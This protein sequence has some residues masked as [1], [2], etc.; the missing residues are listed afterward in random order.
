MKKKVKR[1]KKYN[2][3]KPKEENKN[4]DLHDK[5]KKHLDALG[6]RDLDVNNPMERALKLDK[7]KKNPVKPG[8]MKIEVY[9]GEDE[10]GNR[11]AVSKSE[12]NNKVLIHDPIRTV[13]LNTSIQADVAACP[14][15]VMPM[16]IDE[17]VQMAVSEDK[18]FKPEKKRRDGFN[19][20]WVV[21]FL[22]PLPGIL[23]FIIAFL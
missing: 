2:L 15:N 3:K 14:S 21:F 11:V 13:D 18:T 19:W 23:L 20:W 22:M 8:Y 5:A 1:K 10:N 16:L 6:T 12:S 9:E 7:V 4:V 17:Y